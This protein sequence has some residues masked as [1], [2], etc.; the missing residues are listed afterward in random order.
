MLHALLNIL[1]QPCEEFQVV[2]NLEQ[3][4]AFSHRANDEPATIFRLDGFTDF[5][6]ASSFLTRLNAPVLYRC[7]RN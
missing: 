4:M 7:D 6:Q 1:P 2:L 5:Q 3:V